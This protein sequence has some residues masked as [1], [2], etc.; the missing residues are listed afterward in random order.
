MKSILVTGGAGFIGAN[1]IRHMLNEYADNKIINLDAL[2]YAADLDN[3]N[4]IE[5]H[6]HYTFVHGDIRDKATVQQV[7]D[8]HKITDVMHL[9]AESHVDNSVSGPEIFIQTNVTG[10]FNLLETAH[11]Y[12]AENLQAHRFLHVSTDEVYGSVGGGAFFTETTPYAPNSPYSASKASADMLVR[13]YH[14]TYGLNTVTTNCSNNY[15]PGQ[16]NE[17]LIPVIIRKA[18]TNEPI[19]I[20]G[21]GQ[22]IRDW[23]YVEDHCRGLDLAFQKSASGD[24]YNIGTRNEWKNLELCETI[25]QL[26]DELQPK[27]SGSYKEQITFVKDRPGHDFRYAI[28][29]SK[30]EKNLGF[31]AQFGFDEAL[32]KTVQWYMKK[33]IG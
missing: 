24:T 7:F 9:A 31:K 19:P 28:D 33:Y 32:K 4:D 25:C 18:L 17:K 15:G 22:N 23:L 16:H 5:S 27:S 6:D 3:L 13:C 21:D 1:L 2:T 10:T 26:L 20:Y 8:Q 14:H 11:H 30:V 12:W 29:P